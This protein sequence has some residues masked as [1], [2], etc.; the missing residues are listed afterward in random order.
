MHTGRPELGI[1]EVIEELSGDRCTARFGSALFSGIP[2]HVLRPAR[3]CQALVEA[4]RQ[5]RFLAL[6]HITHRDNVPGIVQRGILD[7][8][9]ARKACPTLTDISDPGAQR[10]RERAE[11]VYRR[12]IHA[13]APLYWNPLNPMFWAR[14]E[15][16]NELC[17][18]RISLSVLL[19]ME[20][21]FTDGNA[22]SGST[23]FFDAEGC[24]EHV[25]W[26]VLRASR[27][28]SFPDGKRKRCA[29]VLV[30][31]CV[32][33]AFIEA[34]FCGSAE[35][36]A[37]LMGVHPVVRVTERL[38]GRYRHWAWRYAEGISSPAPARHW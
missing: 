35:T 30:Y 23:Q 28:T 25:P 6:W 33:P 37:A 38:S 29:E 3:S 34:V 8:H 12:N 36:R 31:P 5:R 22:A 11:P 20:C 13:Y 14:R 24:L 19:H 21:V 17:V 4:A 1:G 7:H 10:W 32:P 18:L 9:A 15:E 16:T 27:W 26:G 2:K